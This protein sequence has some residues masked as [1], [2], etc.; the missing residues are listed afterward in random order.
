MDHYIGG[1]VK[2]EFVGKYNKA[3]IFTDHIE[4]G[5]QDQI[6]ELLNQE[7]IK[8]AKVRIMP[9]VHQ[10]M[11]CV[12]GFTAEMGDKVIPNI[13]GVDIGC[14]M[15]T[16]ALGDV[17][18][19][20]PKLDGIINDK[21]PSGKYT[22]EGRMYRF[23]KYKDLYCYRELKNTKRIE[24][25][26]GTLGGGNHFIEVN[27]DKNNNKYLVIHSGSRNLG[28]QVAE[29]YQ[30]LAIDLC[31]GKE[32][33]FHKKEVLIETYKNQGR[34]KD[35]NKALKELE[36][37]YKGVEPIYPK[38]LCYL[39]G[40]YREKYLHDMKICQEYAELN[41][42]TMAE[43]ILENLFHAN[44]N[45]F[46]YFHTVHNYID[47]KD[48][49][50]RKGAIAAYHGEKILIPINMKDGSI[51][52]KGKGNSDWN[53]SAPHGA[54]RLKSRTDAKESFTLADFEKSMEG[55]YSTSVKQSTLDESPFAYKGMDEIL[56]N[57]GDTA[58]VIDVLKPIYNFKA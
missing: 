19:D 35:I 39:T 18:M 44:L 46:E 56:N 14:G 43:I 51:L 37:Q 41:R 58:E 16:V 42:E 7:F 38:Q 33:F 50:I 12:I 2:M 9:D 10:G 24:R 6:I 32:E 23:E 8:D 28:K 55:I 13:V 11:G 40:E 53:Y 27:I 29:I 30:R 31:S 22:H 26:I 25:S 47:F 4:Q 48:N 49:I 34:R 17:N 5:A 45:D 15:L 1:K 20:L 54:G 3:T 52:A 21:V 57:I 36:K